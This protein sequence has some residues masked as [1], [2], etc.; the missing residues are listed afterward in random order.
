MPVDPETIAKFS[1]RTTFTILPGGQNE[2]V[3][4]GDLVIKP[5]HEPKKY[6][7]LSECLN[8]VD[9]EDLQVAIPVRSGA[10]NYIENAAGATQYYE[11][12]FFDGRMERKLDT[13]RELN[14]KVFHISKPEDF[15]SWESPWTKGQDLAWSFGDA[16]NFKIPEELRVLMNMREQIEIPYQ[17]VHVDLAGN[18]LFDIKGNPVVIDFTPGFYPKEY[19]E[20][21]LVIDSIAW[22]HGP[23][24]SLELLT[25]HGEFKTQ[26]MLRS[27]IFRL[28]VPLFFD[29]C[30]AENYQ[31]NLEGYK[32]IV[33]VISGE[34]AQKI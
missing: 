15:A 33:K 23:I 24:E 7:W 14:K 8:E 25:I 10:G 12:K 34:S 29:K 9:F 1:G 17:L 2:S 18:I 27:L 22:Y 16:V 13:C 11:A 6:L 5:V 26:L 31:R 28:S 20:S 30:N 32:P 4:A 19:S 3:K 21:L